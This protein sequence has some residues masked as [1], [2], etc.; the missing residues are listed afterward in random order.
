M[1]WIICF[2][3]SMTLLVTAILFAV[4]VGM[5]Y[6]RGR[7]LT[8][9]KIIF[10]GMFISV[11]ICMLPVFYETMGDS[12]SR[13]LKAAAYSFHNTLQIFTIDADRGVI[14]SICCSSAA[15]ENVYSA[16]ISIAYVVAPIMTFGFLV[17]F[18]KNAVSFIRYAVRFF[19]PAYVFSE[20]NGRSISLG[21]D[22][23][24]NHK[25]ATIVYTDVFENNEE[26]SF[27]LAERARELKAVCFKK[28]I[29]VVNF[30]FH[31]RKAPL[32][33][34][35]I[36]EDEAENVD[37]SLA[38]LERY[39]D[40]ES[41]ELYV[42]STETSGALI[43]ANADRGK[44]KLRRVNEVR[45]LIDRSLYENGRELFLNAKPIEG[46]NKKI[47]A[48]IVGMGRHGTEMLKA[49]TWY[50]QMDGYDITIDA[51]DKDERAE[52]RFSALAPELMSEKLN[53]VSI[54]GEAEYTIRIHS[55]CDV[56]TKSFADEIEKL[57][58]ATYVFVCLDSDEN[59]TR[60]AVELR[61]LFERVGAKPVIR[62]VVRNPEE[63]CALDGVVN[64]K[65]RSYD[66]DFIGDTDSCYSEK[67]IMN[68]ELE[69]EALKLHKR[70]G[71]EEE[72]WRY[73][74]N[75]NSSVASAMHKKV[76]R[77][78]GV[79][80]A[81]K[82]ETQL[83]AEERDIIERLEHRR[84]NAYMRSEG[85][86]YSGSN[87]ENSRNDLAKIHHDLVAF[88]RLSEEDKRKDSRVATD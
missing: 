83:A 16:Y 82:E 37:Q 24:K 21:T 68:S 59:N 65:G 79:T 51:F 63:K 53:G 40:R 18:F 6:K 62:A 75:Y 30:G 77:E 25:R 31:F 46:G 33:F 9:F 13:I 84:W 1:N 78:L 64:F 71:A 36:G 42:F 3:L 28:G 26:T 85:Y 67:V 48:V 2:A 10:G 34:F 8:P 74:Y 81:D 87:D 50:C 32:V 73:E 4:I 44:M 19:R 54:P 69:A 5:K 80:G 38:L 45:L 49:L 58:D 7:V 29:S 66:I 47:G 52:E 57:T 20:L 11:F 35:A 60:T 39:R 43:L 23:R 86:V 56:T 15:L 72:F 61:M 70:W 14:D 12:S 88:S 55:G 22:I 41:A 17:S 76:R 27:E